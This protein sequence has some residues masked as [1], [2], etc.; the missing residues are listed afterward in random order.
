MDSAPV[1]SALVRRRCRFVVVGSVARELLGESVCPADLDVVIDSAASLTPAVR[2]G[3]QG[4]VC[5]DRSG[6][7]RAVATDTC[8]YGRIV[9]M[10]ADVDV[11]W[12]LPRST[13][14]RNPTPSRNVQPR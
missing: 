3:V 7:K 13:Y 12:V 9:R 5:V 11:E 2:R 4:S 14:P 10:R 6:P 8:R 1:L